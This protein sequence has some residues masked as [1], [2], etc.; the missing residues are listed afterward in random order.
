MNREVEKK[1]L[2]SKNNHIHLL[3]KGWLIAY[4]TIKNYIYMVKI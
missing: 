1:L 3:G 4:L 2:I